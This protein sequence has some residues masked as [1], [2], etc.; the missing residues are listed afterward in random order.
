MATRKGSVSSTSGLL[1]PDYK[2]LDRDKKTY[3][4]D[5]RKAMYYVH[6]EIAIKKLKTETVKYAKKHHPEFEH[7][8]ALENYYYSVIG[9]PC[10]IV[11]QGGCVPELWQ[12]HIV[13][14]LAKLELMGAEIKLEKEQI[15]VEKE[16]NPTAQLTIQDRLRDQASKVAATFDGWVD[17]FMIDPKSFKVENYDP[18]K[19]MQTAELK[20]PHVR[21]IVS[22]YQ[23]EIKELEIVVKKS[24]EELSEAYGTYSTLQVKK[25][26]K[27][28]QKIN[29]AATLIVDTSKVNRSPR[30]KTV[31]AD[32]KVSK[33]KYMA[34]FAKFGLVSQNP[35]DIIGAKEVWTYNTKTR[36]IGKYIATDEAIGLDVKGASIS[37]YSPTLS[38]EK[39]LRKPEQQLREFKGLG[40]VQLRKFLE[41]INAVAILLK[42][43]INENIIILKI[44][45]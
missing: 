33:L 35:V 14:E 7:L 5:F 15:K 11:N 9:K 36:K 6:Y 45:K 42:G 20:A 44:Q 32:K 8:D 1:R 13:E 2:T 21:Y 17:D 38:V 3:D 40:K 30:K 16:D 12:T 10:Y 29:D 19:E 37:E 39:T 34:T 4:N 23:P 18:L 31:S 26:L 43:R 24:D 27:L 22:F 25:L 28:Y 41:N